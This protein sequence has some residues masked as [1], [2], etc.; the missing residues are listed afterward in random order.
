MRNNEFVITN[1]EEYLSCLETLADT[2]FFRGVSNIDY[3]LIPSLG[4]LFGNQTRVIID[5]ENQI[6]NDFKRKCALYTDNIPQNDFDFLFLAQHHGLPT[7]LLDWT[8]NPL[9]ALY[10]AIEKDFDSDACIYH[11]YPHKI[12][13]PNIST[14]PQSLTENFLVLPSQTHIRYRNQ[15][16]LFMIYAQPNV[17]DLSKIYAKY[18]IPHQFKRN[19]MWKLR[20]IGIT[21]SLLF[22]SLDSLA[23]DIQEMN[24]EKFAS[25]ISKE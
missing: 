13:L 16:G 7:R 8:Y 12:L 2:D 11:S 18:I 14:N 22:P 15:N 6:M 20:K 3:K 25:Y 21:K 1:I 17:E 19:I 24:K 10:F 9:V 4:R 5:F 23:Y